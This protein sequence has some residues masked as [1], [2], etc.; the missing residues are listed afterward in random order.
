VLNNARVPDTVTFGATFMGKKVRLRE[1]F[2][3][4]LIASMSFLFAEGG[5]GG[6]GG[7][8]SGTGGRLPDTGQT[9]SHALYDDGHYQINPPSYTKLDASGS[10]LPDGAASWSMVRD[11]VTGLIWE[12]K[13]TTGDIHDSDSLY[14]WENATE[15][16]VSGLNAVHFGGHADWRLPSVKEL[17]LLF[18]AGSATGIAGSFFPNTR[19]SDGYYWS[20]TEYHDDEDLA[21]TVFFGPLGGGVGFPVKTSTQY[22]RA[23]RGQAPGGGLEIKGGTVTDTRAGLMWQREPATMTWN[24]ALESCNGLALA[25]H[26]D[27]RL[28][29]R[30]ELQSIVEYGAYGPAI[31][32]AVFP[33][34]GSEFYWTSTTYRDDPDRAWFVMMGDGALSHVP[35]TGKDESYNVL[36]VRTVQ[37][38]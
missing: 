34:V 12:S 9:T 36:C 38:F 2:L 27:W 28:P 4:L 20:A 18:N 31:D 15:I 6:G 25:G 7:S 33:N 5:C 8:S 37:N 30:N 29:N 32:Q 14:S 1:S 21:W 19:W 35:G 24:L 13:T 22:V 26:S 3:I 10:T 17:S 16:F 23:V 11:N